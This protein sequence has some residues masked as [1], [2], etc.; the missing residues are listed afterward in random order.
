MGILKEIETFMTELQCEPEYFKES[1][2]FMSMYNDIVWKI[3]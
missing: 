2:I 1:I 3:R